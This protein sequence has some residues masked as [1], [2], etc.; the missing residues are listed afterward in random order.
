M[1]TKISFSIDN[2]NLDKIKVF[3]F[4]DLSSLSTKTYKKNN[5]SIVEVITEENF[6]EDEIISLAISNGKKNEEIEI[7]TSDFQFVED[8][9]IFLF[10]LLALVGGIILNFMPCVLPVLSLKIIA[11]LKVSNENKFLIKKYFI[12]FQVFFSLFFIEYT[13]NFF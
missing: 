7:K 4:S 9:T 6:N 10:F 11:L 2:F 12:L 3:A 1:I 13:H 8:R 5:L